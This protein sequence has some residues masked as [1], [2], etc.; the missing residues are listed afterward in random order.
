M[1]KGSLQTQLFAMAAAALGV[2]ACGGQVAQPPASAP[3]SAV[4]TATEVGEPAVPSPAPVS[5]VAKPESHGANEKAGETG[6]ATSAPVTATPASRV[7]T[8]VPAP[9]VEAAIAPGGTVKPAAAKPLPRK[10][11]AAPEA[12]CGASSCSAKKK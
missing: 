11:A 5:G 10:A 4:P 3:Q 6:A 12:S 1:T 2:A 9:K 8:A 7:E